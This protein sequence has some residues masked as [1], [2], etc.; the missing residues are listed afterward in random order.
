MIRSALRNTRVALERMDWW[1]QRARAETRPD[2]ML[3]KSR[4]EMTMSWT[5]VAT[6]QT[7]RSR[8]IQ[9]IFRKWSQ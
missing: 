7:E 3:L 2:R 1:G 4:K 8:R 6:V 5:R 9:H